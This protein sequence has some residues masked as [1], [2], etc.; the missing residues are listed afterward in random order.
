MFFYSDAKLCE[1]VAIKKFDRPLYITGQLQLI[2]HE[3]TPMSLD[4]QSQVRSGYNWSDNKRIRVSLEGVDIR[5]ATR[6]R[7]A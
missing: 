2:S 6:V 7:I 4:E 5:V 3:G 1:A